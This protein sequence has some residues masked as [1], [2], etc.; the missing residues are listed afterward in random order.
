MTEIEKTSSAKSAS[1]KP[2]KDGLGGTIRVF[3]E[4]LIIALIVRTFLFQP[5]EIPSGSL[6][7]TLEIGDYLFVSKY[8]YGYSR[9]S[10]P[11]GIAPFSGRILGQLPTQGDIAVFRGTFDGSKDYIKRVIGLPGD[12][13]QM[14]DGRLYINDK[15]VDRQPMAPH[16]YRDSFGQIEDAPQYEETLPNGVKHRII[17]IAGDH[18]DLDNTPRFEVPPDHVFMMGDNRDNSADSRVMNEMGYVPLENLEGKAQMIFLSVDERSSLWKFWEWP[19]S[20]R[21]GRMFTIVR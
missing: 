20:I 1:E 2:S 7:P 19:W 14:K 13:V 12:T 4:A 18:G 8:S 6:I 5:F 15:L 16:P 3:A 9:Y 17:E 10:F 11:F 21:F